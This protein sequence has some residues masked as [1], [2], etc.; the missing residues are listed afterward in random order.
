MDTLT[1]KTKY[2]RIRGT[3]EDGIHV[4]KGIP[5]A[6]PP[7]GRFRFHPPLPLEPWDGIRDAQTFGSVAVQLES[8]VSTS[9]SQ[10]RS[11][12]CLFLNIWTP[13]RI[14][15]PLPVM[16]WIHG[17][18]FM[19]GSSSDTMYLGDIFPR[20]GN[21]VYVSMN[22][23]LGVFGFL[24]LAGVAGS[25]FASSGN[26]GLLDQI[27]ALKWVKENISAFGGDP[28]NVTI[29]G[30]S[31]GAIA[32]SDL[33][34]MP[35]AKG[36][37]H[38]AIIESTAYL[39]TPK[40]KADAAAKDFL[41]ILGIQ[42]SEYEKLYELSSAEILSASLKL[43]TMTFMPVVDGVSMPEEPINAAKNGAAAGVKII[44]GCNR[45]EYAMFAALDPGIAD[46]GE[47]EIMESLSG[48][49]GDL[50]SDF[51]EYFKDTPKDLDF[52][53]RV[54]SW[55]AFIHPTV[56]YTEA[57]SAHSEVWSYLFT[58]E[59]PIFKAGHGLDIPFVFKKVDGKNSDI[60][61]ISGKAE[62][63]L[64]GQMFKEWIQFAHK[65]NPNALG[66]P[67]WLRFDTT[68]RNVMALN[69][70][71]GIQSD[72]HQDRA[73]WDLVSSKDEYKGVTLSMENDLFTDNDDAKDDKPDLSNYPA[74][75]GYFSIHD[76]IGVILKNKDAEAILYSLTDSF[77][78]P[79]GKPVKVNKVMMG[80]VSQMSLVKLAD[81]MGGKLS[82]ETLADINM[83]LNEVKKPG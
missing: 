52:Y 28:G 13:S 6:G 8:P 69:L 70:Q 24:H 56:K 15:K 72:P 55:A 34:A 50:W 19:T 79:G 41:G 5:Y 42:P 17:G 23:R 68:S 25:E 73:F 76:N 77:Q 67:K 82:R 44:I 4:F 59:H 18:A 32:V 57:L 54:M 47:K 49:F 71:S 78:T 35:E 58:Y 64:S 29:F 20:D 83:R 75:E 51:E 62:K 39:A 38:K 46:W 65:G 21:V 63:R 66:L 74:P 7:L 10:P 81:M 61:Q 14:S 36:L 80:I 37:F 22:Y 60:F 48:M 2:G 9:G 3:I 12:D 26:C 40:E 11:E 53:I 43:P 31:A 1:V 45:D 33:L 27:A 30:E 16:V